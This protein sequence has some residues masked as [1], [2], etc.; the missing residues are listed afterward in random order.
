MYVSYL[1]LCD[2][3]TLGDGGVEM[4]EIRIKNRSGIRI[5]GNTI[6]CKDCGHK[7]KHNTMT[8]RKCEKCGKEVIKIR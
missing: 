6:K 4:M 1:L 7:N 3:V 5:E 8:D 2:L